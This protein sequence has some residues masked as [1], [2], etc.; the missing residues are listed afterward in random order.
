MKVGLVRPEFAHEISASTGGR[1]IKNIGIHPD[2]TWA[3]G[4]KSNFRH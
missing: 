4:R 3:Y 1:H 2:L